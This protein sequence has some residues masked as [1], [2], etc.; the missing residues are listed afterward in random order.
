[1][2]C[3]HLLLLVQGVS[4]GVFG[5]GNKQYEH[6]CEVGKRV[7]QALEQWGGRPVAPVGVGDDDEDIDADFETWRTKLYDA[8]DMSS[9]LSNS[10]VRLQLGAGLCPLSC[11]RTRAP[12]E[13][14]Y[15]QGEREQ[16]SSALA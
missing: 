4:F 11:M 6:F 3:Q 2:P 5:L 8:L 14:Q 9:L 13:Q 1:M 7:H 10:K 16:P 15:R 12:A